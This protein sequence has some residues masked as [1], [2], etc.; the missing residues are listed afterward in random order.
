MANKETLLIL[1]GNALLHRAWHALPPLTTKDGLVVNAAYGFTMIVEKMLEQFK[2][3]YM[4]VGWDLPG[5]TFRHELFKDYKAQRETKEQE[6]YDQIPII[7]DLMTAYGVPSLTAKGFEADDILATLSTEATK[8][9]IESLIVTGDLDSLQLVDEMVHVV[10]FVKGISE[11]KIYDVAAVKE[12]YGLTPKELVDYKALRGD[13]SDNIPGVSGI[14]EKTATDLIQRFGSIEGIFK[15]LDAGEIEEKFAKKLRGQEQEALDSR[16]L[17]TM[18]HDVKTGFRFDQAR[19]K[20]RNREQLL[21]QFRALEF[22]TLVKKYEAKEG[23]DSMDD[24]GSRRLKPAPQANTEFVL[25]RTLEELQ[26]RLK[27]AATNDDEQTFSVLVASQQADLFGA[28]LAAVAI[29]NGKKTMVVPNPTKQ[30]LE[31]IARHLLSV[32]HIVTHDSKLLMHQTGWRIDNAFDTMIASYLLFAGSRAHELSDVIYKQLNKK[33]AEMPVTFATEKDYQKLGMLAVLLPELARKLS[34]E[35]KTAQVDHVFNNIEIPLVP[36]LYEM[37]QFGVELDCK[38]LEVVSRD[39]TKRIKILEKQI[40]TAAGREFNVNSPIQLAEILFDDLKLDSKGIKKT[41]SGYSTAASELE[42]LWDAHTIIP[43]IS[44]NREL[45]KLMSTYV[46]ALPKLVDKQGRVHTTYNQTIAATGRLSSTDPN[47]QNI[48]IK[49]ELGREIRKAFIAPRGKQLISADYSQIEL[50][51]VAVLAKDQPFIDAFKEGVDIHT[52]TAA[53]VWEV[54][55]IDVTPEQ[56]RAAKAINFGIMYGMGPR[57]LARS[58]GTSMNEARQ[59]IDR[60]FQIHFRVREYLDAM[61]MKAHQDG[62]VET[63]FGRRRYFPEIHSGVPMLVAQAERMAQ[64]MPIQGTQADIVKKAMI[65]VSDWLKQ[66]ELPAVMLLQVHDELVFECENGAV[67]PVIAGIHK[68]MEG[69]VDFDVPL[70]VDV[71]VGK[72]WG[73]MKKL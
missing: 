73:E 49:T 41:K 24:I 55:E 9:G 71:E 26:C 52:R 64:N 65:E 50:R 14:G 16:V 10:F 60:Y 44:E 39:L 57:S 62:F 59:F 35:M 43:L 20:E 19:V 1:D 13:P 45:T 4:A 3:T 48:P 61:K 63:L 58:T 47:L 33:V 67:D 66:S 5:D 53:E 6:L 22:R 29:S 15:A 38:S 25:V 51:I 17:V 23:S 68:I 30:Q 42:K 28:T 54:A 8:K 18:I 7:Q 72:N 32:A 40:I 34:K 12:R 36:I 56:R 11:T 31:A 37:E 21:E 46:E 70:V 69:V 27:P 2:P